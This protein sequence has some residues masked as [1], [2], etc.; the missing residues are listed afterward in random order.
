[1]GQCVKCEKRTLCQGDRRCV[2]CSSTGQVVMR[3]LTRISWDECTLNRIK[4]WACE[5]HDGNS[6][7]CAPSQSKLTSATLYSFKS[8]LCKLFYSCGIP[9]AFIMPAKHYETYCTMVSYLTNCTTQYWD[10]KIFWAISRSLLKKLLHRLWKSCAAVHCP[11]Y[12][13]NSGAREVET[14]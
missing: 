2:K 1:M 6:C 3:S 14:W 11:P 4:Q 9:I 7:G 8:R 13:L 5:V 12:G 10:S